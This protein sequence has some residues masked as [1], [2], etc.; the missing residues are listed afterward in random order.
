MHVKNTA[1]RMLPNP[2]VFYWDPTTFS[3]SLMAEELIKMLRLHQ[4]RDSHLLSSGRL[5]KFLTPPP[6]ERLKSPLREYDYLHDTIEE[7]DDFL[8]RND[9][10]LVRMVVGVHIEVVLGI[11]NTDVDASALDST[12]HN[13]EKETPEN[14]VFSTSDL[15]NASPAERRRLLA[16]LY[17][18][19]V[20]KKVV[21]MVY[22]RK[23]NDIQFCELKQGTQIKI[24]EK[25]QGA[26]YIPNKVTINEI[27]CTLVFRMLFWLQLHDFHQK[28]IQISKSDLYGSRK[29]VYIV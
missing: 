25:E 3:M 10:G 2:T 4:G 14:R 23:S 17:M 20:R 22:Q 28:D 21:D 27:W 15:D 9:E 26:R 6:A 24:E 29:P 1:F 13:Q 12:Q 19:T 7:L 8:K 11:L 16:S 5:K 18:D